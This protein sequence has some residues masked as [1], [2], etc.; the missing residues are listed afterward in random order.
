MMNVRQPEGWMFNV[1]KGLAEMPF[2]DLTFLH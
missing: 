2:D 1:L